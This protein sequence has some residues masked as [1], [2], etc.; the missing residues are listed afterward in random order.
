MPET[1]WFEYTDMTRELRVAHYAEAYV[2]AFRA[3]Y[4]RRVDARVAP[5]INPI[6][7][8]KNNDVDTLSQSKLNMI[9]KGVRAADSIGVP[10]TFYCNTL[11][12]YYAKRSWTYL[13]K[14][15]Q[16]YSKDGIGYVLERWQV[17]IKYS[18]ELPTPGKGRGARFVAY[19]KEI[20]LLRDRPKFILSLLLKDR[21]LNE[22]AAA[23]LFGD[24]LVRQAQRVS[25]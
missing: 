2:S 20:V 16:L 14:L 21:H 3:Q 23:M 15:Q 25:A 8:M 17:H 13:P 11:M 24:D 12:E 18:V 9:W 7:G 6:P 19:V 5:H 1:C 4:A 22:D 10:Y